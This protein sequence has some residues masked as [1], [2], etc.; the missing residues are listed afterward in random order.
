MIRLAD[1]RAVYR[2]SLGFIGTSVVPLG[3]AD[4]GSLCTL[5]RFEPGVPLMPFDCCQVMSSV[6]C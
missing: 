4:D 3:Y 2:T 6:R 1:I 5:L